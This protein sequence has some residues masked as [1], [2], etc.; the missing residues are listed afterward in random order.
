MS[1]ARQLYVTKSINSVGQGP[2]GPPGISGS[3]GGSG[4][5]LYF[6]KSGLIGNV[7]PGT[8][9]TTYETIQSNKS[10]TYY[11]TFNN[12][13]ILIPGTFEAYIYGNSLYGTSIKISSIIVNSTNIL[14]S[15]GT[16]SISEN[17]NP[18]KVSLYGTF[19]GPTNIVKGT[20]L[21]ITLSNIGS[22]IFSAFVMFCKI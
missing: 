14:S 18:F 13:F 3:P 15:S 4:L 17:S 20:T 16:I 12:S 22:N 2:T 10:V 1:Y 5:L 9:E 7:L 6:I 21:S 19:I 11:Y 8:L